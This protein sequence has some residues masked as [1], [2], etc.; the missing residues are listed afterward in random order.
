[1]I[2]QLHPLHFLTIA[3]LTA[4]AIGCTNSPTS[5]KKT[6]SSHR[7]H[8][9][10]TLYQATTHPRYAQLF[11]VEYHP[12]FKVIRVKNPFDTT[13]LQRTY[14]LIPREMEA[15]TSLP[16]GQIIRIPIQKAALAHTTHVGFFNKLGLLKTISGVSQK[17][18][19][20][21]QQVREAVEQGEIREF[22]PSHNINGE[23]LLYVNPDL[24]FVAPF[25]DN[26]YK[27]IRAMGIPIAVNASY[28]ETTPLGRAEWIKF[29]SYFFNKEQQADSIFN[30]VAAHYHKLTE[31][32]PK[33]QKTPTIFSG[34]KI[35]QVWY[36]PGGESY[37]AEFF[38]DAG[39]RYLWRQNKESGSLPLDF[40]TVYMK[41][42]NADYW[43]MLEN[44]PGDYSYQQLASEN[45]HY[46]E[47][48][49]FREQQVILCNTHF[50]PYY[51]QGILEPDVIL[52][53]LISLLYPG[54]LP[55]HDNKYYQLLTRP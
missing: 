10:D 33:D 20:K 45:I 44:Y 48:D 51:E 50:N 8:Q 15:D 43:C 18:Y 47:F 37:M 31:M 2:R 30:R 35:G 53:D 6:G 41:A 40:E 13:H 4:L 9:K 28:M 23:K 46:P 54:M 27:K 19:I 22:G 21:N 11:S 16:E 25:K 49:A 38:K 14:I 7:S 36:V 5:E 39:A 3:F 55:G 1:M 34:K 12:R 32:V 52:A 29:I 24:L 17:K 26:R 42:K